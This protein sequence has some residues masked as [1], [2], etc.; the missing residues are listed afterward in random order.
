MQ[1]SPASHPS[2]EPPL[3]PGT[4]PKY[5]WELLGWFWIAF[6]LHQGDRQIYNAVLPLI[7]SD[8]GASDVELGLVATGFTLVYGSMV[9]V[10]GWL[11]DRFSKKWIVCLSL[12][13]FSGGTLLTG[14]AGGL[15]GLLVFRSIA[16]GVGEAFY[17]PAANALIAFHHHR[18]RAQA[19]AIHQTAQYV[20]VVA[21]S[22]LAA[23]LGKH[24]GWRSAFWVFG[25]IGLLVAVILVMRIRNDRPS[26]TAATGA[27]AAVGLK[28]TLRHILRI[29]TFYLLAIA[30]GCLVFVNVGFLTWTPTYLYERFGLPL[31]TAAL[32]AVLPHL[33]CAAVG[34]MIGG[35]LSDA[36]A[37]KRPAIRTEVQWVG[38]LFGA[39][40]IY[41]LGSSS[42]LMTVYIALGAFGF[43]R[44]LYDSNIF[45]AVFE[46]V[47]LRYRATA[48]GL[49]LAFGFV[50]G[51][52]APVVLG[53]IKQNAGLG[54]GLSALALVFALG[55]VA[56]MLVSYVT[57]ARDRKNAAA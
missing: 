25:V 22:V 20:G 15:I 9:G 46:V 18:T 2:V 47:A 49:T 51:A 40:F 33:A 36:L 43:F 23:Y 5:R 19:M 13:V 35:R 24:Y 17:Y 10:A 53:W 11:S 7:R 1:I 42:D 31:E 21:S 28:E 57:L 26:Q 32:Q 27:E 52:V 44:G 12:L 14:F 8:L 54:A 29:P 3:A 41:L 55:A 56:L 6:F 48:T 39:P 38:L 16:T 34:V 4:S 30:F 50:V 37:A 45:A